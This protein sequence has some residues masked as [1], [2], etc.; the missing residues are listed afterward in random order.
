M[1]ALDESLWKVSS[2]PV[3]NDFIKARPLGSCFCAITAQKRRCL[4]T[5]E[6]NIDALGDSK[7][8]ESVFWKFTEA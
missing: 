2:S 8:K 4:T 5:A 7:L 1:I 3:A 6:G